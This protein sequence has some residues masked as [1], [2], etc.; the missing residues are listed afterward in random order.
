VSVALLRDLAERP[1]P[2]GSDANADARA[3]VAR[4]LESLGF[5]T[6]EVPFEFSAFP[7]RFAMPLMGGA[8]VL[9][10]GVAG[11]VG[12]RGARWTPLLLTLVFGIAVKYAVEWLGRRG[13]LVMPLMRE[14]GVNL[15]ATRS[16]APP[17]VWLCAHID[18]KSQPIPTLV[19]VVGLV[20]ASVGF[21]IAIVLSVIVAFGRAPTFAWWAAAALVTLAGCVPVGMSVV[22][23]NSPG[24][25]DNASGVVTVVEA[26]R[27][28][29]AARVGVL[30]TDAEEL[31]LAGARAWASRARGA[32]VLNCDGVDDGGDN[33]VIL[34]KLLG[35]IDAAVPAGTRKRKVLPGLLTDA[36]AF[37]DAGVPSVTFMRGGWRSLARVHS[38]TDDLAHLR[39][40]G[41]AEVAALIAATARQ[42][43]ERS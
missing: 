12:A 20:L 35:T 43:G 7:G 2:T 14:R 23:S 31:G 6:R 15:E 41:I 5:A 17:T 27:Q 16:G 4:E 40:T 1:R 37:A 13:V 10:V 26:A 24:A 3:R 39:G 19:R 36:I 22:T 29:G 42:L 33:V 38:R 21:N 32:V 30:I 34:G 11:H 8:M 28:L 25:L 9:I 18:T